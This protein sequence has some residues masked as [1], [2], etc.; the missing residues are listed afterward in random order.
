MGVTTT[1]RLA[2][3]ETEI[4]ARLAE[5]LNTVSQFF[6]GTAQQGAPLKTGFLISHILQS[7]IATSVK[8]QSDAVSM[9]PYS[10]FQNDGTS[11]HAGTHYWTNAYIQTKAKFRDIL[12]G[13]GS[14][15]MGS[16][17]AAAATQRQFTRRVTSRG[18]V[19][20]RQR[21]HN[22]GF[23]TRSKN[24]GRFA[25]SYKPRPRL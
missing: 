2:A 11:R 18:L 23:I 3:A 16:P 1:N 15:N 6:V 14:V 25:G 20:T 9:A 24:S 13:D 21:T 10:R 4:R 12:M 19:L 17:V 22:G 5:R 7:E 8:L